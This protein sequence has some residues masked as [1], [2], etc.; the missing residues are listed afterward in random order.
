MRKLS[1]IWIYCLFTVNS[2]SMHRRALNDFTL[3]D[4][5]FIPKNTTLCA[6]LSAT[7]HDEKYYPNANTFDGF[8]F[9]HQA[10]AMLTEEESVKQQ[11]VRESLYAWHEYVDHVFSSL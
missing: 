5:T 10:S 2:V 6:A 9:V 8:R 7:H 4:G 1:Y 3:P 11:M